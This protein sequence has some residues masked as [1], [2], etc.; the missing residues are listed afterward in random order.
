M[1]TFCII[2]INIYRVTF[3]SKILNLFCR[4]IEVDLERTSIFFL[5]E[6][7]LLTMRHIFEKIARKGGFNT[8][9]IDLIFEILRL[10]AQYYP[11]LVREKY[12]ETIVLNVDIWQY[13]DPLLQSILITKIR[14]IILNDIEKIYNRKNIIDLLL[15]CIERY[16][17]CGSKYAKL[18]EFLST[19]TKDLI[20]NNMNESIIF[21]IT[22]YLN[23]YYI[24][25]LPNYKTFVYTILHILIEVYNTSKNSI[26]ISF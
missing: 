10:L 17:C 13:S 26:V 4:I 19:I 20:L 25:K 3:S 11:P 7:N 9:G 8:E 5:D 24:R 22:G 6:E 1:C 2:E 18:V 23:I 21:K 15:N 12:L 16:T 14:D